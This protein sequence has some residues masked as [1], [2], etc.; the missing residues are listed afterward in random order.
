MD[1]SWTHLGYI[2]LNSLYIRFFFLSASWTKSFL[3]G[4]FP[5]FCPTSKS[6]VSKYTNDTETPYV[7][8]AFKDMVSEFERLKA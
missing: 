6:S 4:I 1:I 3:T 5:D 2:E 7:D 8:Q